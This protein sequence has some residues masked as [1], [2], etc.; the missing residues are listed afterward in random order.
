VSLATDLN[1]PRLSSWVDVNQDEPLDFGAQYRTTFIGAETTYPVVKETFPLVW[2]ALKIGSRFA[3]SSVVIINVELFTPITDEL[4][5]RGHKKTDWALRVTWQRDTTLLGGP[6]Q[7]GVGESALKVAAAIIG[8][9]TTL[10]LS[11]VIAAKFT[12]KQLGTVADDLR[13]TF[14]ALFNP[15]VIIAVLAAIALIVH[16]RR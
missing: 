1:L 15:G 3:G 7:S 14:Q 4:V 10:L 2:E 12:E 9:V 11:W 6:A 16:R 5:A 13:D 8:V